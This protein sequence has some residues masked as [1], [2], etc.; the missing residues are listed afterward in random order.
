MSTAKKIISEIEESVRSTSVK[1]KSS[2]FKLVEIFPLV[3][4]QSKEQHTLALK[5]LEKL[6]D[7]S[8]SQ[9]SLDSGVIMYMRALAKLA[10][11]FEL[12]KYIGQKV[13]GAEMLKYL[14]DLNGLRQSDLKH[15]LG[16]Q[17]V[18]SEILAGKRELN[19]KQVR[20]LARRF[21]VSPNAFIA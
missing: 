20:A 9:S 7:Y 3:E 6:V 18:V 19:L 12:E 1:P 8:N 17:S 5:I 21:K 4:I 13:S 14:M 10:E 11:D 16:G 15:E 2:Y